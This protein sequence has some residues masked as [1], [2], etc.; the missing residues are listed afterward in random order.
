M[1]GTILYII[2]PSGTNVVL[3]RDEVEFTE[4]QP[5][6]F[7]RIRLSCGIDDEMFL[8]AFSTTIKERLTEGGASGAFFFFSKGENFIA[9]SCTEEEVNTL[10]TNAIE[11]ANFLV[12]NP[13]SY[14]SKI[15]GVYRLRIYGNSLNFFVMN[16]LFYNTLGLTMNEKYD[17]KGSWVAR[18]AKPPLEGRSLTCSYCEQKFVYRKKKNFSRLMTKQGTGAG[19]HKY[20]SLPRLSF[21]PI[22]FSALVSCGCAFA[23]THCCI[24]FISSKMVFEMHSNDSKDLTTSPLADLHNLEEGSYFAE[25]LANP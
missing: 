3:R 6:Q 14:I 1:R 22:F 17:I 18:N 15:L 25:H 2:L 5:Y 9:K 10:T 7:R 24:L 19:S 8:S 11:Y 21:S 4:F 23:L 12:A 13:D 20:V 16:N